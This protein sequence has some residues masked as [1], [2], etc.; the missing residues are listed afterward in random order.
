MLNEILAAWLS[1]NS[2]Q[3]CPAWSHIHSKKALL[4]LVSTN[5]AS[6]EQARSGRRWV[7]QE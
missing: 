6:I 1:S 4:M 3:V 5:V 2:N 7:M